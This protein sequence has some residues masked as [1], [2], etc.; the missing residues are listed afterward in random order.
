MGFIGSG[1]S[2]VFAQFVA[3]N[4]VENIWGLCIND[5]GSKANGTLTLGSVD[6]R[7]YKGTVTYVPYPPRS[8]YYAVP[9][10]GGT[11]AGSKVAISG[12]KSEAILDSGTNILLLNDEAFA[13]VRASFSA[14]CS[15]GKTLPGFCDSTTK[16]DSSNTLFDKKCF[17]LT[18][19]QISTFPTVS[20]AVSRSLSLDLAPHDY[21]L[22][23][24]P[25]ANGDDSLRCLG[26]RKT[27]RGGLFIIGDTIMRNYY[28]I[29]DNENQ[30][31]GWAPVNK[32]NCGSV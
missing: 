14:L 25:R 32:A 17:A 8:G 5:S 11:V 1:P 9:V 7:L 6:D 20:L 30:R 3:A 2:T 22:K 13:G 15:A 28:L 29:F 31:T 24:D 4:I 19:E 21:L 16:P 27:G 10:L 18:T 12:L 26:I 23:G